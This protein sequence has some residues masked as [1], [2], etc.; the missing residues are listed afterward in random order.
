M[1]DLIDKKMEARKN[2]PKEEQ[3]TQ[4]PGQ[5]DDETQ[6]QAQQSKNAKKKAQKKKSN[7]RQVWINAIKERNA[8][9]IKCPKDLDEEGIVE[10][11]PDIRL[12][13]QNKYGARCRRERAQERQ[14]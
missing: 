7:A 12:N 1:L 14:A 8:S 2:Q 13:D 3:K 9:E 10:D 6:G 11:L 5:D 4:D